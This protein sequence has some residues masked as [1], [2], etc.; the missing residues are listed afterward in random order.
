MLEHEG[1]RFV[2]VVAQQPFEHASGRFL[3]PTVDVYIE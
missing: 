1:K 3:R 2:F